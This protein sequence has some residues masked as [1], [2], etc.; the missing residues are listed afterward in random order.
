MCRFIL[1]YP[2][3]APA[4]EGS[5]SDSRRSA[6]VSFR[7][8]GIRLVDK[9]PTGDILHELDWDIGLGYMLY[10]MNFGNSGLSEGGSRDDHSFLRQS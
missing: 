9:V 4:H 1:N 3:A 2:A 8:G 10:G 7:R 6:A 5:V